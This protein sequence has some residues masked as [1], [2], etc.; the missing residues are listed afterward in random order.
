MI[1]FASMV[2]QADGRG[3]AGR[4]DPPAA[5]GAGGCTA[6]GDAWGA[7]ATGAAAAVGASDTLARQECDAGSAATAAELPTGGARG[8]A[9]RSE[10]PVEPRSVGEITARPGDGDA[11]GASFIEHPLLIRTRVHVEAPDPVQHGPRLT[12]EEINGVLSRKAHERAVRIRA[13]VEASRARGVPLDPFTAMLQHD[14]EHAPW[15]TNAAQLAEIGVDLPE[16]GPLHLDD[17]EIHRILW[18]TIYG[19]AL[20]GIY[21]LETDHLSDRRLLESLSTRI[22]RDPIRDVGGVSEM[23][24]FID[25]QCCPPDGLSS[26]A[27]ARPD[28]LVGPYELADEDDTGVQ[29]WEQDGRARERPAAMPLLESVESPPASRVVDRDRLLPRPAA[30]GAMGAS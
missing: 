27:G 16:A 7:P 8:I 9:G 25:L 21:L 10:S 5:G 19:L 26:S 4:M 1:A 23:C 6:P 14:F 24:E 29:P 30:R 17:A 15:T 3:G 11:D 13:A 18:R 12:L 2:V 20:L 22:L 28:G